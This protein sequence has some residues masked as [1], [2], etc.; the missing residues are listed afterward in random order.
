M[1]LS[2]T[3]GEDTYPFIAEFTPE[4]VREDEQIV[5][6]VWQK[7]HHTIWLLEVSVDA[8]RNLSACLRKHFRQYGEPTLYFTEF[9]QPDDCG[10]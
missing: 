10:E 9:T 5:C 4:L 6:I 7:D 2:S 8:I 1:T 3:F